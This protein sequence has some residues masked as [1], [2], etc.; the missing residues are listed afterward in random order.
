M[1]KA[2]GRMMFE[3]IEEP[4]KLKCIIAGSR[5][6]TDYD[7]LEFGIKLCPFKDQIIE[8]VNHMAELYIQSL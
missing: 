5:T 1:A 6:I 8:I 7:F 4:R 3:V 2:C